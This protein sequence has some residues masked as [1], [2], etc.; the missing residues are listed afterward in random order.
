LL[1][2]KGVPTHFV[3][4][5]NDREQVCRK[6]TMIPLKVMVRNTA[7]GTYA[8][9]SGQAEGTDFSKPIVE[10]LYRN[11]EKGN[12]LV[13]KEQ[14]VSLGAATAEIVDSIC[15]TA[16]QVNDILRPFLLE[17]KL[18]LVDVKL[19]F[20]FNEDNNIVVADEISPDTCRIWDSET[21][22]KLDKDRF[23]LDLGKVSESYADVYGRVGDFSVTGL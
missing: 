17:K 8:A 19:E 6:V 21:N 1:E 23:I 13:T 15:K 7:A 18:K 16:L 2:S 10:L 14:A 4:R 3:T 12:P 5:V 11:S 9:R 20:G 22:E